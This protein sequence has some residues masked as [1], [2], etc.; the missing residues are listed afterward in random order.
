M[1]IAPTQTRTVPIRF[2]QSKPFT[3][4]ELHITVTLTSSDTSSITIV[5]VSLPIRQ[6]PGWTPTSYTPI[7]GSY[8][9]AESMPTSFVVIP[10]LEKNDEKPCPPILALR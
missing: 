9:F 7:K 1:R 6:L 3:A 8:F 2:L 10:P 5:V 4:D